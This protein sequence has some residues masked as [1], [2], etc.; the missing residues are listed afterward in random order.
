MMY[1]LTKRTT[2][3]PTP[4]AIKGFIY[5]N[6]EDLLYDLREVLRT[7]SKTDG[8]ISNQIKLI[9]NCFNSNN[10]ANGFYLRMNQTTIYQ[11]VK[12]QEYKPNISYEEFY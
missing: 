1:T 3:N 11:I 12:I 4:R 7:Y 5:D 2:D 9:R 8:Y 10:T 6:L